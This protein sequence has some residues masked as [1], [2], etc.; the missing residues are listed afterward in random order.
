MRILVTRPEADAQAFAAALRERDVESVIAPVMSVAFEATLR[1]DLDGAQAVL[2]TSANGVRGLARLT[3]RRDLNLLAVGP[4]T[5]A[6]ARDLGF[7]TVATA[8]GDAEGLARLARERLR[9]DE[10]RLIHLAGTVS[11]GDLAGRLKESG[12]AVERI[13]AYRAETVEKLPETARQALHSQTLDG[14]AF[15]SPRTAAVFV[16]LVQAAGLDGQ[17]GQL[18]AFCLSQ[19]VAEVV[20]AALWRDIV[21]AERPDGGALVDLI[22][23]VVTD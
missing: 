23:S 12:F 21:V 17:L 15:F 1:L 11:A 13:V 9:P 16:K 20:Q 14:A 22:C 4:A 10:G 5:T 8:T 2:L 3:A 18:Q 6:E 19:A 7:Q